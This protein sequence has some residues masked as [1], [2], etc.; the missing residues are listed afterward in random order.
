MGLIGIESC[1]GFGDGCFNIPLI[2]AIAAKYNS[3][4]SVAVKKSCEDVFSNVPCIKEIINITGLGQGVNYY[5]T[6]GI[7]NFQITQNCYFP[8][9]INEDHNH[10]L[11]ATAWV[12]GKRVCGVDFNPRPKIYLT[13]KEL[14]ATSSLNK[15]VKNVAIESEYYS[16][17][18]WAND[19]DFEQI[20]KNNPNVKFW[21]LSL[22]HPTFNYENMI[23]ASS[24]MSRRECIALIS[25]CDAFLSVGSGLFCAT[26]SM[27]KQP[28]S[29][30]MLWI[31]N[32]YKYK[33]T[34]VPNGWVP[35][36]TKWFDNRAAWNSFVSGTNLL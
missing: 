28:K 16:G 23:Y 8:S 3:D 1:Y 22:R 30:W 7:R 10:S 2:E 26:L 36:N 31:D 11:A 33:N 20:I 14:Q 6:K 32:Y 5:N 4:I 12:T 15:S 9:Y 19:N 13:N 17:Q 21:W 25:E 29:I 34:V 24:I 18:S 27:I 35:E